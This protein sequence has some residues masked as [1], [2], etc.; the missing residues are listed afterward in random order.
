MTN[1]KHCFPAG[2]PQ[3]KKIGLIGGIGPE[4]TL[5]YYKRVEYEAQKAS[6]R[7]F[8]PNIAIESIS[9]HDIF[10]FNERR[11]YKGLAQYILNAVKC[12]AG[13]GCDVA[14]LTGITPHVVF[15]EVAAKAPIP[16]LSIVTPLVDY[17]K[18][19]GMNKLALIATQFSMTGEFFNRP[20][21][22]AGIELVKPNAKEIAFIADKMNTEIEMGMTLPQTQAAFKGIVERMA[23]ETP[24]AL[25]LGCTELPGFFRGVD[26]PLPVLNP[27]DLHIARLVELI[28]GK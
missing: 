23:A 15:D 5:D 3:Q 4:S 21:T 22:Q 16:M 13:A 1:S 2:S 26:L 17:A 12:L 25:I 18:A 27:M 19:R 8:Y 20:F 11:D 28:L 9:V 24:Q 14:T 7:N 6:G 10:A